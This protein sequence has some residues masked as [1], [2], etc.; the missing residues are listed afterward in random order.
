MRAIWPSGHAWIWPPRACGPALHDGAHGFADVRGQGMGLF[1]GRKGILEDRLQGHEGHR[2]LRT[3]ERS[4]VGWV[5]LQYHANY[6]RDKRLVQR[7]FIG[8]WKVARIGGYRQVGG[9]NEVYGRESGISRHRFAMGHMLYR[10]DHQ[11]FD[12]RCS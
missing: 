11:R 1:V 10:D 4:K 7:L 5:S 12:I 3:R 6:P 9:E 8:N 2:G